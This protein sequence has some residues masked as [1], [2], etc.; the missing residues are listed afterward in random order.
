MTC[1]HED[2]VGMPYIGD[3]DGG[4]LSQAVGKVRPDHRAG[5]VKKELGQ[6]I[7]GQLG[8]VAENDGEGDGSEQRLDQ[9]PQRAEDGLFIDRDEITAH[10]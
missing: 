10:E 8:D 2:G 1:K 5:H 4:S 3:K 6:A 7:G 9:K